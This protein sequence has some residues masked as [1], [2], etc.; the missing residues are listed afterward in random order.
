MAGKINTQAE[1]LALN[2]LEEWVVSQHLR[3]SM[4]KELAAKDRRYQENNT[5][6]S[7]FEKKAIVAGA[8]ILTV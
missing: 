7:K 3:V 4:W 5:R 8:E 2:F 6:I 1:R